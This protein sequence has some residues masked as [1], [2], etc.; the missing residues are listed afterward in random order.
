MSELRKMKG[1]YL[2]KVRYSDHSAIAKVYTNEAGMQSFIIR[3]L[4]N[5]SKNK[6][7]GLLQPL[8][9][10]DMVVYVNPKRDI[11]HIKEISLAYHFKNLQQKDFVK[12]SIA[13]F[14][15]ELIYNSIKEEEKNQALFDFLQNSI[16]YL[17]LIEQG[18]LNFHLFFAIQFTK[19]L[20]F[21]PAYEQETTNGFFDLREGKF[22]P[23]EPFHPDY[24][25]TLKSGVF[26]EL[27]VQ[28][29]SGLA[30]FH[31]TNQQR[32]DLLND[33]LYYYSI[34]L[35]GFG[36]IKSHQILETVLS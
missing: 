22:V 26:K 35:Q 25:D 27:L 29:Y 31:I 34:H 18:Y 9:L 7:N 28:E 20:G 6:K 17:D 4:G 30:G 1:I 36:N 21:F 16:Q 10:L 13:I 5:S 3:G 32:R 2:H 33:I 23:N 24:M 14:I 15:N 12:S 11:H 8:T 19:Y